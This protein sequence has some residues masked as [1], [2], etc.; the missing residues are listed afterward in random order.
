MIYLVFTLLTITILT[1]YNLPFDY[2]GLKAAHRTASLFVDPRGNPRPA[3]LDTLVVK[4][5]SSNHFKAMEI[6]GAIKSGK[7]PESMDNDGAAVSAFKVLP[8]D[9]LSNSAYWYI[10]QIKNSII[11]FMECLPNSVPV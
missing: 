2:S 6:L 9:Y 1:T 10:K 8:L 11:N 4:K 5:G 3:S 7:I